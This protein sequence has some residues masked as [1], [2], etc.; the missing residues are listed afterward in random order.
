MSKLTSH[1]NLPVGGVAAIILVVF[2]RLPDHVK[3]AEATF[4]EK[5][6]QLDPTGIVLILCAVI[7]YILAL[8]W[9]GVSLPWNDSKVIGL[10]IG[11]VLLLIAFGVNEW[12]LGERAML[13]PRLLKNRYIW[14]GMAYSFTIA[15]TYFLV[16]YYLPIYFQ[17]IDNV[18]PIQSGV[19]N[20]PLILAITLSTTVSGVGIT[21]TGRSTP[22]MVV[23]GILST[24]GVGLLYTLDIG[25]GSPKWIGYQVLTGLG[26]GL[27][28]QVPVSA[29]QATLPQIDIPSGSAMII[30]KFPQRSSLYQKK[31]ILTP[32][33]VVQTIG[34]AFLVSAGQSAFVAKLTEYLVQ[35]NGAI[36]PAKVVGTGATDIRNVFTAEELPFILRG[37]VKGIQTAFIVS[38]ALAGAC[39]LIA[40]AADWKK[41]AP[42]EEGGQAQSQEKGVEAKEVV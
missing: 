2:F 8:Q 13:P 7:C 33:T 5:M 28:F 12:W 40:F 19:R 29:A 14:Q 23:A 41:L 1:S 25:T 32:T 6:L 27:G 16:L 30:C 37:Y 26:L 42:A 34:G 10:F 9:G 38:I 3:P 39:T 11:F 20:L 24:I 18:S 21:V 31:L 22:F 4:R 36:S 15:G 17:V 35:N